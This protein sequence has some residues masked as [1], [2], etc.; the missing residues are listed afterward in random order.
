MPATSHEKGKEKLHRV[1]DRVADA[2]LQATIGGVVGEGMPGLAAVILSGLKA[3][4]QEAEP[5]HEVLPFGASSAA[6]A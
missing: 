6:R 4:D 5:L 2:H 3:P 1:H